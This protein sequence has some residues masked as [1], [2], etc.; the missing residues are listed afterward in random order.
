MLHHGPCPEASDTPTITPSVTTTVE[1]TQPE[2]SPSE[3]QSSEEE[4]S[5]TPTPTEEQKEEPTPTP[6][7]ERHE[8]ATPTPTAVPAIGGVE[9]PQVLG[10][11][12]MAK[13]GVFDQ[14]VMNVS[15]IFGML[16]TMA[17][18]LIYAKKRKN[19]TA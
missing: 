3:E 17:G 9:A 18:S 12:T 10:M 15:G 14:M 2:V 1:P 11:K 6:T 7:E 19:Q 4:P 13:A 16:F 5:C 8:E